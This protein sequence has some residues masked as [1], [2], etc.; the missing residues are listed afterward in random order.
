MSDAKNSLICYNRGCGQTFNENNNK[1][2]SCQHHPGHPVFHDAYKGWSCC[3]KKSTDFSEFLNIKG[4]TKSQHS[5]VKPPEVPKSI[6]NTLKTN[7]VVQYS[8]KPLNNSIQRPSFDSPQLTLKPTVTPILLEQIKNLTVSNDIKK[9]EDLIIIGQSCKH[10]C[11]KGIY[12]G[13][14]S[15]DEVC[16][17]HPGVPV[18]HEGI[19]YWSCCKKKTTDFTVFLEQPGCLN[20][21]HMWIQ[22]D[23]EKT[24]KCRIDWYQTSSDVIVSIFAKKYDPNT[25]CVKLNPIHLTVDI[26]FPENNSMYNLDIELKEI[27]NIEGSSVNM[28]PTKVEIKL[29]KE[30]PGFWHTLE[31]NKKTMTEKSDELDSEYN[32]VSQIDADIGDI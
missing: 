31:I 14:K 6:N 29:K 8:C 27:V 32:N 22:K 28:L 25:S 17:Y 11:C 24:A 18:F 21:N 1:E 19:K 10:N 5:N 16:I 26:H 13:S 9:D 2:D 12:E 4:C 30:E 3:K 23:E 15:N 7:E 20:G